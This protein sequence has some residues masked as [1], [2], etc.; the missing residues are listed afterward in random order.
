MN[1]VELRPAF[2]WTCPECGRD[3]FERVI[4]PEMSEEDKEIL[5]EEIGCDE[6]DLDN[7][8]DIFFFPP[9]K[10]ICRGCNIEF[11][12]ETFGESEEE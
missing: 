9:D 7:F 8:T 12:T 4:V 3:R 2:E 1:K 11:D 6:D 10:V 5:R